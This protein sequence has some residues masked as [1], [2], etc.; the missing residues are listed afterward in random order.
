MPLELL[1]RYN[2]PFQTWGTGSAKTLNHLLKE[3]EEGETTLKE[4]GGE[5]IRETSIL[6][7]TVKNT[8][9]D[10]LKEDRQVFRDGRVRRREHPQSASLGEKLKAGEV[11]SD[12][13]IARALKE[14]LGI[15]RFDVHQRTLPLVSV[16]D[17]PSY[18]GLKARFTE[19]H[20]EVEIQSEDYRAEGY[21]EIQ[22]DKT[23][24]FVWHRASRG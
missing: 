9:G 1:N 2:I 19:H 13:S 5:L 8:L 22:H 23:T 10:L 17:S 16:R 3:I 12:E 18:P 21:L 11:P 6:Y 14:E 15:T 7:I 20:C 4:E 24:Y